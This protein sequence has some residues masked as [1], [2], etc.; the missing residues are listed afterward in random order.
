MET[1]TINFQSQF[2]VLSDQALIEKFNQETDKQGWTNSRAIFLKT[3]INELKNRGI[4]ISSIYDGIT[5][6]LNHKLPIAL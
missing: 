5:I 6:N 3:L 2:A 1:T 4:D